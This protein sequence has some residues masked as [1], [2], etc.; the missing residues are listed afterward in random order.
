[1]R[2]KG[3]QAVAGLLIVVLVSAG[4]LWHPASVAA[5]I[6]VIDEAA[7]TENILQTLYAIADYAIQAEQFAQEVLA[8]EQLV[9]QYEVMLLNIK[10][11]N[12]SGL[13]VIGGLIGTAMDIFH[14]AEGMVYTA[15]AIKEAFDALWEPFN[16][17]LLEGWEF[18]AKGISWNEQ[19]RL[20]H[21]DVMFLQNHVPVHIEATMG[22]VGEVLTKSAA[23]EGALQATQAGNEMLG[24]V[25][26][27]LMLVNQQLAMQGA[28]VNSQAMLEAALIDQAQLNGE[29]WMADFTVHATP[30][31]L[32]A[33]PRLH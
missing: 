26:Q 4:V 22:L 27:E 7:L 6:P 2:R 18:H 5:I 15:A 13:P 24:T 19:V 14:T 32:E 8:V 12:F 25:T 10:N 28:A 29:R 3:K 33:L 9:L 30:K 16:T 17:R 1:M 23:A 20:A 31:G 11:L 21:K